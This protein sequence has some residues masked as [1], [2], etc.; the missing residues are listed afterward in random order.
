[1]GG[2]EVRGR[3]RRGE[4]RSQINNPRRDGAGGEERKGTYGKNKFISQGKGSPTSVP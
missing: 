1:M 4:M 2:E 3:C